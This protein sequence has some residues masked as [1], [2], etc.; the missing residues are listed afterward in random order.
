MAVK[1]KSAPKIL[2]RPPTKIHMPAGS[3]LKGTNQLY[4][5]SGPKG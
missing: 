4:R 2:T 5:R 1:L 3:K